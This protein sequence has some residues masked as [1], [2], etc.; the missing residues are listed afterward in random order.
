M[1]NPI[2]QEPS[3]P[4]M[5]TFD[6]V[7]GDEDRDM[8]GG[9]AAQAQIVPTPNRGVTTWSPLMPQNFAAHRPPA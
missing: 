6:A 1:I 7:T 2:I 3:Y 9:A 5:G 8:C 4:H